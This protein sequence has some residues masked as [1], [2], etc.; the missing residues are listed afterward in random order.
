[1]SVITPGN[2]FGSCCTDQ[3]IILSYSHPTGNSWRVYVVCVRPLMVGL[4][5]AA[6]LL[7]IDLCE[8]ALP[9]GLQ[10]LL[11][12][13]RCVL[14]SSLGAGESKGERGIFWSVGKKKS[15]GSAKF[16]AMAW[17]F[18][19]RIL[20]MGKIRGWRTNFSFNCEKNALGEKVEICNF[21]IVGQINLKTLIRL[22]YCARDK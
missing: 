22:P 16:I 2:L 5:H 20:S 9:S 19:V 17:Q 12:S 13:K 8:N 15:P 6:V 18:L 21:T 11:L 4:T 7:W 14:R 10:I 1:M 3:K